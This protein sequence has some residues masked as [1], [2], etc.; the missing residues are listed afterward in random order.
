MKKEEDQNNVNRI[1]IDDKINLAKTI[2]QLN[3]EHL[4]KIVKII[5]QWNPMVITE[6]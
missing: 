1:S 5:D 3:D 6:V 2:K 4:F